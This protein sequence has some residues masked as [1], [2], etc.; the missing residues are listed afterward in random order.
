MFIK[1]MTILSPLA[2]IDLQETYRAIDSVATGEIPSL[3]CAHSFFSTSYKSAISFQHYQ[4]IY[5]FRCIIICAH[6]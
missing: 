3:F 4:Q 1:A 5:K 6:L 2:D